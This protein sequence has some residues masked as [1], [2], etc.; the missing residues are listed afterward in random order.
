MLSS[1]AMTNRIDR[2]EK[3]ELVTHLRDPNDH[4]SVTVQ[5]Y[6]AVHG[7]RY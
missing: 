4:R 1:E 5:F 3:N 6:G 7:N 2:L